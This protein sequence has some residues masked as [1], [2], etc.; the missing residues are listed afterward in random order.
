MHMSDNKRRS[1]SLL[2]VPVV[3]AVLVTATVV[4]PQ[5]QAN[6]GDSP[7]DASE[8]ADDEQ[9]EAEPT[10][11]QAR[12]MTGRDFYARAGAL[13]DQQD[14]LGAAEAWEQVLLL[15]P[16]REAG[17]RV[18]LAHAYHKAY[19]DDKN[20]EHLRK[21]KQYLVAQ[22]EGLAADDMTRPDIE[23]ELSSIQGELDA[24]AKAEAEAKA[25]REQEIREEQIR[26]NQQALAEAEAKHQRKIQKIYFG[27]GGSMTGTG[28]ATL[29]AMTAFLVRGSQLDAEGLATSMG[30][31][32]DEDFYSQQLAKG[33]NQNRAAWAT[34][35]VGGALTAA[36]ASL[37]IV[38]GVRQRKLKGSR[39]KQVAVSPTL[40]GFRLVF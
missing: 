28:V 12:L 34:G 33:I 35:I 23:S 7:S 2:L 19:A 36:G 3:N 8:V 24:L 25:Q 22:L 40:G 4:S 15:M 13:Y 1:S 30:M 38:A 16:E 11:K 21:S 26:L 14:Y 5:A 6:Q 31:V 9:C 29:G 27:V 37:L 10:L 32:E 39:G 18:Q 20:P 17:L